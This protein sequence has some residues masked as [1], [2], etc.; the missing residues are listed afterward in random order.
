[1]V[2]EMQEAFS[3]LFQKEGNWKLNTKENIE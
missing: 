3:T 2:D 1:M